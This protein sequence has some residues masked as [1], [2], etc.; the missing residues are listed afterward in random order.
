MITTFANI[1]FEGS[2]LDFA[3]IK[4]FRGKKRLISFHSTHSDTHTLRY[5]RTTCSDEAKAALEEAR[6]QFSVLERQVV[7]GKLYP[8][9]RSVMEPGP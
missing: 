2:R 9:A 4:I 8:S 7:L 3:R 6:N 1:A 5:H